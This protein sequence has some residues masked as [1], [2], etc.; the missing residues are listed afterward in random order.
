MIII[1]KLILGFV[2][3]FIGIF[4]FA[5]SALAE[6]VYDALPSVDPA[7]SYPSQPFQAQ[8][9]YEFGDQVHLAGAARILNTVTV[10]MSDYALYADYVSD[11]RYSGNSETWT[12]PITLNVYAATLDSNN[13]P[14]TKLGSITQDITI[15]WRP[16]GDDTCPIVYGVHQWKDSTGQCNSGYAFNATFDMSSLNLT[17]PDDIIIGI[18]FNTQSYGV[19]PIAKNG[20]YNS[21][22]VAVPENQFVTVGSEDPNSVFLNSTLAGAYAVPTPLGIFRKDT[23]WAPYGTVAL[24]V[25]AE[26]SL[27]LGIYKVTSCDSSNITNDLYNG[28]VTIV[29][30]GGKNDLMLQ[31]VIQGLLPNTE[32]T[33]WVRNLSPRYISDNYIKSYTPLGYYAFTTFTTNKKGAGNFSYKINKTELLPGSYPIQVALNWNKDGP[34]VNGCTAAATTTNFPIV[35]VGN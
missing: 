18:A 31:G 10:T 11:E 23:G 26:D 29:T 4:A 22:N 12:H 9:V 17:L 30:P 33:V 32:Y 15:P 7:T 16:L 27:Q 34:G 20:P 25:T 2:A 8:Q 35:H 1:K 21:L 5:S 19:E 3:A 13:V 14:T 6:T 24:Q 28:H